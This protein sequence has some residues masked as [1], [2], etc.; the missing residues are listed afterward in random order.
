MLLRIGIVLLLC[1]IP[2]FGIA[3]EVG[4]LVRLADSSHE[5][6][7]LDINT[8]QIRTIAQYPGS[9]FGTVLHGVNPASGPDIALIADQPGSPGQDII[10][11]DW[12]TGAEVARMAVP[13]PRT[14]NS[15][16]IDLDYEGFELWLYRST[17][18]AQGLAFDRQAVSPR[19]GHSSRPIST[20]LRSASAVN[21]PYLR[22]MA[23]GFNPYG[24]QEYLI[25]LCDEPAGRQSIVQMF[26][27]VPGVTEVFQGIPSCSVLP[28]DITHGGSFLDMDWPYALSANVSGL[29]WTLFMMHRPWVQFWSLTVL[30]VLAQA[31]DISG[32]VRYAKD[33]ILV[34][35][36]E[37]T[38][39]ND[40]LW[41]DSASAQIIRHNVPDEIVNVYSH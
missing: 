17:L 8:G 23:L 10:L 11:L 39:S 4:L 13:A 19:F 21:T 35:S 18:D 38:S 29:P 9:Q 2:S 25:T 28:L 20:Y 37:T 30:P 15:E 27:R 34:L 26:A 36:V 14:Q 16:I 5:Y 3:Q 24:Q 1:L 33:D 32:Q 22:K 6:Q 31:Q 12:R 40:I 41:L 7:R